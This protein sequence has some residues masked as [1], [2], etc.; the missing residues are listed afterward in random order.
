MR[1]N[2]GRMRRP[3]RHSTVGQMVGFIAF[4]LE[5]EHLVVGEVAGVATPALA[6]VAGQVDSEPI[7]EEL[8]LRCLADSRMP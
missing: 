6:E 5:V 1:S 2:L 4:P 7:W 3:M 8:L